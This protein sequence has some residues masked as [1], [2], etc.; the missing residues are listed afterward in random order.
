MREAMFTVLG[1]KLA[2]AILAVML[3]LSLVLSG[4][5]SAYA[6]AATLPHLKPIGAESSVVQTVRFISPDTMDPTQPGVGT[7]RYAYAQNDPINKSDPNGH[8]IETAWDV[9]NAAYG[10]ASFSQN[11]SQGNYVA[12]TIDAAGATIDTAAAVVPGVPG[13]ATAAIKGTRTAASY[14]VDALGYGSKAIDP[15]WSSKI[16]G[17]AQ[18]TGKDTWH[19]DASYAKAVEY[20]KDPNVVSVHLDTSI[21]KALGAKG[22][23]RKEPDVV[24][25]YKDGTTVHTCECVSPSQS[26]ASAQK[27]V[28][29]TTAEINASGRIGSGEVVQRGGPNDPT[30]GRATGEAPK[31]GDA[32]SSGSGGWFGGWW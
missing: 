23:S 13:G 18:Q 10:W 32:G 9:A 31:K 12:A 15:S 11:W 24:V 2:Q 7:N 27:K 26:R 14:A 20:A 8:I 29:G 28:D 17:W 3:A 30:G 19:A 25:T 22:V 5:T 1:R 4:L 16:T 6:S 21:D